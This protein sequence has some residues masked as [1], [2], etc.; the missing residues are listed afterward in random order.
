M[1]A[2]GAALARALEAALV[3]VLLA[4]LVFLAL[5]LLPG[6]PARLVL[7]DQASP[8][9]LAAVRARLHTDEPLATQYARFLAGLGTFDLGDSLRRPGVPALRRVASALGPTA[10]LAGLAVGLG[11]VLGIALAAVAFGPWLGAQRRWVERGLVALAAC[12]LVA[13]APLL[14][15]ALAVKTRLVPLPGDPDAGALGL[16]FASGL[17]AVPLAAHV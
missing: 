5:R 10:R 3:L 4:S 8:A 9:E 7:G 11:S 2:L 6:D 17:L 15:F 16:V 13:F 12:P 1:R 14:T